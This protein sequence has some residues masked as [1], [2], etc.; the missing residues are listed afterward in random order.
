MFGLSGGYLREHQPYRRKPRKDE[1]DH[2]I[3]WEK[4]SPAGKRGYSGK[5]P[6]KRG[7]CGRKAALSIERVCG[8]AEIKGEYLVKTMPE[9]TGV[10]IAAD[11]TGPD[12][13]S[14]AMAKRLLDL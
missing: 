8:P 1:P 11:D 6:L 10:K 7:K 13:Y 3:R 5:P 9:K 4:R 14:R 12:Q 2:Y